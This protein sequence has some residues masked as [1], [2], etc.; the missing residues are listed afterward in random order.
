MRQK[1]AWMGLMAAIAIIFGYIETLLP[2]FT[3]IPGIKLGLANLVTV[4]MLY[5]FTW[6]EAAVI[7]TIRI[8]V[9]GFLFGSLFSILFSL[10]GGY[11]SLMVMVWMKKVPG[12]SVIGVSI[13][14]G[15]F[16]NIGQILVAALV[17]ENI[18]LFYY[19]PVLLVAGLVTGLLIGIVGQM[20]I[21]RLKPLL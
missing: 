1:T 14:G 15:V 7:A 17:V 3:G 2:I 10:A 4:F 9:I 20:L 21:R 6:K 5:V 12:L 8:L 11:L 19:V 13:A 16:H 18:K